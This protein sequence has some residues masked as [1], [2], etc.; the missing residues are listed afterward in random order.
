MPLPP[1]PPGPAVSLVV[2][3]K[4]AT[5]QQLT[6]AGVTAMARAASG[7][8]ATLV[9]VQVSSAGELVLTFLVAANATDA[10]A[11][12]APIAAALSAA[13]AIP[14]TAALSPVQ[15]APQQLRTAFN[16]D[17]IRA[18][19]EAP[20]QAAR[21]ARVTT[22]PQAPPLQLP[23]PAAQPPAGP[24]PGSAP[25]AAIALVAT[26]ATAAALAGLGAFV[27]F[28]RKSVPAAVVGAPSHGQTRPRRRLAL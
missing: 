25:V 22:P 26:A 15:T 6:A 9:A 14:A 28:A 24:G 5:E 7:K 8:G 11:L 23:P 4:G 18:A 1:S 20:Q 17:Q 19:A 27:A 3:L 21:T 13:G 10:A 12:R 2:V 16:S